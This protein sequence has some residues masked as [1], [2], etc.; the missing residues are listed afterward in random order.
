MSKQFVLKGA[1]SQIGFVF[2]RDSSST[3]GAGLTGL[4]YNTASLVA[5]YVRPGAARQSITLATQ[6][7]TG[8][9][10][11]GGF[12]EVDAT[13]MPGLYR[14]DI[15]D[16]AFA[17]GVNSVVVSLKGAASMEPCMLEYQLT[18]VNLQDS[19][20]AG[21]TALPNAAAEAAGGLFTRGTGAGQIN[22]ETNGRVDTNLVAWR[23]TQPN[24]L[25]SGRV[26][27]LV[28]AMTNG[29][30]A[31]ATFAANA[32]DAVW[33]TATRLLT[34]GT[35]IVL[36]KGTGITGLND[37]DAAGIRSAAGLA[38][39]NLDTQLSAINAKTTNL[40][41]DPADASDIAAAF[42]TV[43]G[44]LGTIAGYLDT[45]I[46]AIKAKTD[47]MTFTVANQLDVN[48]LSESGVL[49]SS[50]G[51]IPLKGLTDKGTAQSATSTTVV[52]R[53]AFAAADDVLNG[54]VIGVLG[55]T[56]G[57]WQWAE[58]KDYVESTKTVTV[59]PFTV[60]PSGT[61]S[62]LVYGGPRAPAT[63]P[64]VNVT[65]V[66]GD[67]IMASSSKSTAWGGTP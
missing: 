11:S 67:P 38:T 10:S 40:P 36:A 4:A 55:S 7:V 32:L 2:I 66:I 56:Q 54:C 30:I 39:A 51:P 52:L 14:L 44:T 59:D 20:R 16:A 45:E 3:V 47:Q 15:P 58:V 9:Y 24:A 34:A 25:T 64:A 48:T 1:T 28:G 33:S 60:T 29:V 53:S 19:V 57:Y 5:S 27:V 13:N 8:A 23:G 65:Q 22:Q 31:A 41:A 26:E 62:Y 43:D 6:T 21:M 18:S 37:L 12:V 61:I 46:A 50:A 17:T 42:S 63:P 35:N 49:L